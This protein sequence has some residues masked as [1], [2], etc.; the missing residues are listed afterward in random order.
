MKAVIITG[1]ST[2]IGRA[3]AEALA[4][5]DFHVFAGVRKEADA[6]AWQGARNV[7]ALRLDVTSDASVAEAI[8]SVKGEL[9]RAEEVHLV[10]NAG[11]AVAG[12]IEGVPVARWREQFDVNVFGLVRVTQA[13]LPFVRATQ[14][15]IVNISSIS[16]LATSPYLGVYSA[17]KFS[18]EAISDALRRELRQFGC[19]VAVVEPGPIA[20]PIWEKNL[21]VDEDP[22]RLLPP[23]L[24]ALYGDEL[25]KFRRGVEKAVRDAVPARR[26]A[27]A[28][29]HALSS[30]KPRT[31]YVV[32]AK[33][34]PA[35]MK[36]LGALP[37][38]WVDTLIS[39]DFR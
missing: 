15:R 24:K 36:I 16:G 21:G 28:I 39:R 12:P 23:E 19:R 22:A 4:E 32:G 30:P 1:A 26:V 8:A 17:S 14:G 7:R 38:S 34:L 31:R 9:E 29:E 27:K 6:A 11:I 20:T 5:R 35:Q 25:E 18:V 2:G 13:V 10:N 37:D 3:A 33:T